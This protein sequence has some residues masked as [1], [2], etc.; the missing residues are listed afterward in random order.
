MM[1]KLSLKC[2]GGRGGGEKSTILEP[3]RYPRG[4]EIRAFRPIGL[5][6]NNYKYSH[7][8]ILGD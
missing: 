1:P 7:Y 6:D 4:R 3:L 2:E 8:E 5:W